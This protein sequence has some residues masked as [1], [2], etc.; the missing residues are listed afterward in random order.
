MF[1]HSVSCQFIKLDHSNLWPT[2]DIFFLSS[3]F[4]V[5]KLCV[6]SDGLSTYD[7]ESGH[8]VR[9]RLHVRATEQLKRIQIFTVTRV[10]I[11]ARPAIVL[12]QWLHKSVK[13]NK[14]KKLKDASL[15][16]GRTSPRFA[17]NLKWNANWIYCF[18]NT[19]TSSV[20]CL[21]S[22]VL[23]MTYSYYFFLKLKYYNFYRKC[24]EQFSRD[25][26]NSIQ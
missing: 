9:D 14:A 25:F 22:W 7:Q 4:D 20:L 23:Y 19:I 17:R 5:I 11:N 10:K 2:H 13:R 18:F 12:N 6:T 1:T 3:L 24:H 8:A 26:I 15:Q 21:T 16:W